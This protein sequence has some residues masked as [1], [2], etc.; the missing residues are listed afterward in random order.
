MAT[1]FCICVAFILIIPEGPG[2]KSVHIAFE[3]IVFTYAEPCSSSQLHPAGDTEQQHICPMFVQ[4][5]EEV[6]PL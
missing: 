1:Y 6:S 4:M 2:C 3:M 5:V